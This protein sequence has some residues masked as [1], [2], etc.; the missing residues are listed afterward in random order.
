M[1]SVDDYNSKSCL[2]LILGG[3]RKDTFDKD[4]NLWYHSHKEWIYQ[5]KDMY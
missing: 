4:H 2:P 5:V 1:E 3:N